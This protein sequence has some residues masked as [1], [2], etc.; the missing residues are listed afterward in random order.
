MDE[1]APEGTGARRVKI[2]GRIR[3]LRARCEMTMEVVATKA[4][5]SR[6]FLSRIE[7]NESMPSLTTLAGIAEALNVNPGFFFE[8]ADGERHVLLR[9]CDRT[10]LENRGTVAELLTRD[11]PTRKMQMTRITIPPGGHAS[12]KRRKYADDQ[13]G[14]CLEGRVNVVTERSTFEVDEDDSFYL[15]GPINYR[16]ENPGK[17][18]AVVLLVTAR[19]CV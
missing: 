7:R 17:D 3:A 10:Q 1:K 2:G 13:C 15:G 16:I 11:V 14:I 18:A 4:G 6:A 8:D 5:C 12:L 19:Q 9:K